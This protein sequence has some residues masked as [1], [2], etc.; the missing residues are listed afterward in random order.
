MVLRRHARGSD[1]RHPKNTG[2]CHSIFRNVKKH[3]K[4]CTSSTV[5]RN[6]N[7][8]RRGLSLAGMVHL[9]VFKQKYEIVERQCRRPVAALRSLIEFHTE[10]PSMT[11]RGRVKICGATH[12]INCGR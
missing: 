12:R 5:F 8:L 7:A 11:H 6:D 10:I 9:F 4:R 1:S 3:V 2:S